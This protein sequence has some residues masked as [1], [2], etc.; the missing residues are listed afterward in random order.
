MAYPTHRECANFRDG[1]CLLL[2]IEVDPN[3]PACPNFTPRIQTPR[4]AAPPSPS[5]ELWRIRMELQDIS[6]RIGLLE[7]RLRRLGR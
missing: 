5:L 3:G 4:A 2:G 6:R 7:M 1:R